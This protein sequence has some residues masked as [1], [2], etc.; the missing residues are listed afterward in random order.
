MDNNMCL[1]RTR[2]ISSTE[3]WVE[4]L[5]DGNNWRQIGSGSREF[6]EQLRN[7]KEEVLM[8]QKMGVW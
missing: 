4:V 8:A 3:I 1:V 6:A 7:Q 5:E 2:A